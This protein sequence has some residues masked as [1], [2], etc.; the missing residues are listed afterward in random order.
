MD[1]RQRQIKNELTLFPEVKQG[2]KNKGKT[3]KKDAE[4]ARKHKERR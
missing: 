3:K 2:R 4:R 1:K